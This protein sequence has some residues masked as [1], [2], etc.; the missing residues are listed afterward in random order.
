MGD[1]AGRSASELAGAAM[2]MAD[3]VV[4]FAEAADRASKAYTRWVDMQVVKANDAVWPL[5]PDGDPDDR[6]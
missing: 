1:F 6:R 4:K 2:R 5:H 3:G